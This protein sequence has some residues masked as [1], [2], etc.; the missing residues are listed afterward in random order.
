MMDELGTM[1]DEHLGRL[2]AAK[3]RILLTKTGR[4]PIH[5]MPCNSGPRHGELKKTE[6]D[7]MLAAEFLEPTNAEWASPIVCA[8]KKDGS[9]RTGVDYRKINAVIARDSYPIPRMDKCIDFLGS[10]KD[11]S[12]HSTPTLAIG[13]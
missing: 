6:T 7:E 3:L 10:A 4:T 13:K 8:P 9:L 11:F 1:W 5:Q 2:I 12:L